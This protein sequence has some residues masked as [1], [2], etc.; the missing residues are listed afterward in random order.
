MKKFAN[1]VN[2]TIGWGVDADPQ[3]QPAYPMKIRTQ[4]DNRGMNW[5]RPPLQEPKVEILQSIERP[6]LSAVFG[7]TNPP[8][9]LS[10]MLRRFAFR[11]SESSYAHW[12]PLLLADRINVIEG[13]FD[14]LMKGR[15]PNIP[16][17]MGIKAELK[18]NPK[19]FARKIAI[20]AVI[21]GGI[22]AYSSYRSSK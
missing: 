10:G 14:D 6:S 5:E 15:I 12:M 11:Y 22:M 7:T 4:D 13:I 8:R 3:D 20:G 16:A 19:G 18:H 2:K 1:D 17:E 9:G 21:V